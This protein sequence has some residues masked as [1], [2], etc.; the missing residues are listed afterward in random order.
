[1]AAAGTFIAPA[2]SI[3]S[4]VSTPSGTDLGAS[5]LAFAQAHLG[6]VVADSYGTG[7]YALVNAALRA[8]GAATQ[9][10]LGWPG[11]SATTSSGAA[12]VPAEPA[13]GYAN[14][15]SLSDVQPG[16]VI[17]FDGY[18]EKAPNVLAVGPAPLGDRPSVDAAAGTITVLQQNWNGNPASAGG[19]SP[20]PHDLRRASV[21]RP[22]AG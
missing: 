14:T 22:T 21:Y 20:S 5:V 10:G 11:R 13:G 1:M 17:Q 12:G 8:A 3:P 7:C 19:R 2:S 4:A 6:Q 18:A 15:G 16:D 9:P